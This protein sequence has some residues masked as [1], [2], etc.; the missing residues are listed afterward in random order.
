[1]PLN[2]AEQ[3]EID[4]DIKNYGAGYIY[5]SPLSGRV[6]LDPALVT[7]YPEVKVSRFKRLV[8][9]MSDPGRLVIGF[10]VAYAVDWLSYGHHVTS[11]NYWQDYLGWLLAMFTLFWI[12][13]INRWAGG[14]P[15]LDR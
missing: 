12:Y 2:A 7:V 15:K 1:M 3:A 11:G 6:R 10:P 9:Y 14:R 8:R 13:E 4:K 5:D